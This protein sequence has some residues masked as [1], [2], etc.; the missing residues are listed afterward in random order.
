VWNNTRT[1]SAWS[2]YQLVAAV[3]TDF[4]DADSNVT[5]CSLAIPG[6]ESV[7]EYLAGIE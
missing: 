3:S 4:T 1:A 2:A 5:T 7:Y 6:A